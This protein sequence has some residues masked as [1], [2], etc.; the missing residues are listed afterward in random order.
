MCHNTRVHNYQYIQVSVVKI[1]T[2]LASWNEILSTVMKL[3]F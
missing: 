2:V 3:N 1:Q